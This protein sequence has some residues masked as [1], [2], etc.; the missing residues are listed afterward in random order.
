MT[1]RITNCPAADPPATTPS[2]S[3]RRAVNQRATATAEVGLDA[4][5]TA[6]MIRTPKTA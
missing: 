5:P 4:P 2:A 1:G 6:T 3:P